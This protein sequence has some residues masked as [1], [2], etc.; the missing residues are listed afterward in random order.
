MIDNNCRSCGR[1]L[2]IIRTG[3]ESS[4]FRQVDCEVCTPGGYSLMPTE[5]EISWSNLN[6]QRCEEQRRSAQRAAQHILAD[7]QSLGFVFEK[8]NEIKKS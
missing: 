4:L 6:A 1:L 5:A 8:K 7:M 2:A 3:C